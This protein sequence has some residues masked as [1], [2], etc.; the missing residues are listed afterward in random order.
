MNILVLAPHPYYQERGTPIAVDMLVKVLCEKG[1]KVDLL[2]F[3]EGEDRIYPGLKIE[4]IRPWFRIQGIR[5]GFSA[6]KLLCDLH[7]FC[8]FIVLMI[9]RRYDVVHAVEESAHMA[10]LVCPLMRI[11]FIHDMDSSMTTQV[12]D[13]FPVLA[14]TRPLL[15]FAEFLPA[16]V[17]AV[18]VPMCDALAEE[19]KLRGA[20]RVFVL[21]DVSLVSAD[22][23]GKAENLRSELGIDVDESLS[24]YIGNLEPYQGIDLMIESFAL[25]LS[26][27]V[28]ARLA[29]I[30][31]NDAHIDAYRR[32]ADELGI[33]SRVHLV[34]RRPV[35][36]I[37]EYMAQ[38]DI[39][40]SPRTHGFNTP[41]KI[42][43]YLDSGRAVLA[44][45]LPT[46]TQVLDSE[47]ASLAPPERTAFSSS[48]RRLLSDAGLRRTLANQAASYVRREHSYSTFKERVAA[49]YAPLEGQACPQ[50]P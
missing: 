3:H 20:K 30:G 40:V 24:M 48:W 14:P 7:L 18:A 32:R 23:A 1:H 26:Q 45:D 25:V 31:G 10:M 6:K 44:T 4:R 21:K 17:A 39:L 2:T 33:S 5:P 43:S 22:G 35:G 28:R 13:K 50:K 37:G 16:R 12:V 34:G 41:M 29:I 47:I 46:H 19:A 36:H 38:A 42:Y 8:K 15:Q 9:R 49:L 27:G 11:P